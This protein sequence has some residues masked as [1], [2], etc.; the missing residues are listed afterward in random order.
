M[1]AS[2][3]LH[4][5]AGGV[6]LT[7]SAAALAENAVTNDPA[8]VRAGPDSSY[9]EVAQLDA[10][11]P[12]QVMGCLDDWSWC[13]VAFADNRGWIYSPEITFEYQGGYVPFY[14]YAPALGV[15]VVAFS[16][17][18]YW[19]SYYHDRPWYRQRDE[20]VH[21]TIH[22]QRPPGPAPS[23]NLPP[24]EVVRADRP[25]GGAQPGQP[26]RLGSA[27]PPHR[28]VPPRPDATAGHID[29]RAPE[30]RPQEHSSP[31]RAVPQRQ[32]GHSPPPAGRADTPHPEERHAAPEKRE[33]PPPR[34]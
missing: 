29:S 13:D 32:E 26:L 25:H 6:L 33:E 2:T 15:P 19:G 4:L 21:R 11:A 5:V 18:A 12:I 28:D 30:P 24:R 17:D 27:E 34:E 14:S 20:W 3:C 1:R 9:P 31:P 7:L 23:H 22:H 10:D 8:S 16:V